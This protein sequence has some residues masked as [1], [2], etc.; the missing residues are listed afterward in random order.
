[1]WLALTRLTLTLIT[2]ALAHG[3]NPY[4]VTLPPVLCLQLKRFVYDSSTNPN[5]DPDPGLAP[6]LGAA[7]LTPTLILT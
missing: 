3:P 5:P 6:D 4:Q 1:M 2:P 7:A